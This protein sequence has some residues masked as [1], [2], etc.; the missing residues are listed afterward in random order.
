MR[1]VRPTWRWRSNVSLIL[2]GTLIG[3]LLCEV[4]LRVT[5]VS[6]RSFSQVD[7]SLGASLVPRSEGWYKN[8]GQ[9]YVRI[10]SAGLRD[11]EHVLSKPSRTLRIAV[12]GDSY[13]EAMQVP[14]EDAFWSVLERAMKE[15]PANTG[16][17]LE[18]INFGVSGYGT[19]QELLTLRQRVWAYSPDIVLLAF[20]TGNDIR[21]N[22]RALEQESKKPYFVFK[23]GKLIPDLSFQEPLGFRL[24]ATDVARWLYRR[25]N[26]SRIFQ[27]LTEVRRIIKARNAQSQPLDVSIEHANASEMIAATVRASPWD[28]YA[29]AGLDAGVYIEPADPVWKEAW[30]VTEG[31]IVLMR[32]EVREKGADFLVV[33]L[34]SGPQVHP[35]TAIRRAFEERLGVPH[36]FYPDFRIRDL[37]AREDFAVLNL[38]PLFETAAEQHQMFLHGFEN[39]G[40]G[41][42]HWNK[43]GHH[44]AGRLIAQKLCTDLP[45]RFQPASPQM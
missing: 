28:G 24:R 32:D 5:G 3:V 43:E 17:E 40:L 2:A 10:N 16:R 25:A 1:I 18:V 4:G 45:N 22:S 11:R 38:A 19:A 44:L 42:G 6:Y 12:L 39:S 14:M 41:R 27:V 31:L 35:D 34:S 21:N 37:G 9:A 20:V 13:A 26:S 7:S 8:E 23:N 30:E 29:E 36:L 15:C 33:T